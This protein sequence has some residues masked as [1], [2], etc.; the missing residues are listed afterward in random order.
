[1]NQPRWNIT[2]SVAAGK[3]GAELV[4]GELVS[5][6]Y[7]EMLGVRAAAGLQAGDVILSLG[8]APTNTPQEVMFRLAALGVGAEAEVVWLRAG[9]EM[10][11]TVT[12]AAAPDDP[13]REQVTVSKDVALRGL[14]VVR[15]NPSVTEELRLPLDAV[16][17]AVWQAE[18][19]SARAGF[20]RG[21]IVMAINGAAVSR[22]A[23]VEALA[24]T[25]ARVWVVDLIRQG[26]PL[27]LRFRF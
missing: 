18:D 12:L 9:A 4:D 21:D 11:A 8:G 1:M 6:N 20:Q 27:R 3:R 5:G 23:D 14:T 16:G 22:P 7:F 17:V 10:R 25:E 15:V 19:L 2:P 26:Q 13:P 24:G